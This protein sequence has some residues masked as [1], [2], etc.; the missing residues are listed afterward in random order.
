MRSFHWATLAA[1]VVVAVT[2]ALSS[3][4]SRA[5]NAPSTIRGIERNLAGALEQAKTKQILRFHRQRTNPPAGQLVWVDLAT[6]KRHVQNYDASG[7]FTG[8]SFSPGNAA[9]AR[10]NLPGT[11]GCDIDPFKN[12][13]GEALQVTLLGDQTVDGTPAFHLRFKVSG[14]V[15]PSVTDF[16]I[17]R[18]TYLPV[19]SKVVYR[20]GT[21]V[22]RF[23]WLRRTSASLA[24]LAA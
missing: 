16:W 1:V 9:V 17:S 23:T 18:S 19:H 7:R 10:Q 8:S 24:H 20:T 2:A 6:G 22:D 11:C 4:S 12:F 21:T 15:L 5:A 13:A 14:G 3:G